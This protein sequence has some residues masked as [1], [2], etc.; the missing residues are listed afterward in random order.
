MF[1]R[2]PTLYRTLFIVLLAIWAL[3]YVLGMILGKDNEDRSRRL[4]LWGKLA[5]IGVVLALG[6]VWTLAIAWGTPAVRYAWLI[7]AGLA[8]GALGDLL[9]AGVFPL[10]K[11]D[12]I[13]IGAFAV[14]HIFYI[15]AILTARGLL[16]I[17]NVQ[18]MI[19]AV[20]DGTVLAVVGWV[21]LI[22]N[23]EGSRTLNI[24]SLIYGILLFA[25]A[26]IATSLW[27]ESAHLGILALGL[28]LFAV[29]DFILAQYLIRKRGFTYQRDVVWIIYS[30]AQV[31]IAFS[32]GGAMLLVV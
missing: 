2:V 21:V 25:T 9:L 11:A 1:A 3:A 29:S 22:N 20:L 7:V 16:G 8:A 19:A 24:A 15:A 17:T 14:G 10:K 26:A 13:G 28:V 32:I 4:A 18:P 31:L 23:P 12:L 27:I 5:M 30:T 6:G